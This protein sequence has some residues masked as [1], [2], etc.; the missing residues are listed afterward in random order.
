MRNSSTDDPTGGGGPPSPRPSERQLVVV[1][2][3]TLA[4]RRVESDDLG[5]PTPG[6][7]G[8]PASGHGTRGVEY[9]GAHRRVGCGD[10]QRGP[11]QGEGVGQE[12]ALTAP[13]TVVRPVRH[14]HA[15]ASAAPARRV[16][17]MASGSGA[18]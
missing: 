17:I 9:D 14:R 11:R 4:Q 6:R 8:G 1:V 5:V 7:L 2:E 3:P 15:R 10:P 12:L 18:P 16:S 13:S